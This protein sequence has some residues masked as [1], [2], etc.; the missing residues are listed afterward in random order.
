MAKLI[1]ISGPQGS[2]K[3]TLLGALNRIDDGILVD[4]FKVSRSVQE[5]L[6]WVSLMEHVQDDVHKM[7]HFQSRIIELK[8][9]RDEHNLQRTDADVIITDRTFIDILVYTRIWMQKFLS[10]NPNRTNASDDVFE[11]VITISKLGFKG[12]ASY[13]GIIY[14]PFMNHVKWEND[15]NRAPEEHITTF[16]DYAAEI[17]DAFKQIINTPTCFITSKTVKDRAAETINFIKTI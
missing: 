17:M 3:T 12:Q 16:E 10:N 6:G 5:E 14:V 7:L 13:D 2:G 15:L 4:D 11:K 1:G 8:T 9:A